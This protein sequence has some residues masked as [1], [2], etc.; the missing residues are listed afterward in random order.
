MTLLRTTALIA[1]A[2]AGCRKAEEAYVD[3]DGD[4]V[5]SDLD[6]DD[7]DADAH[8]GAD[9]RC[10]GVDNDCDAEID[11][12]PVDAPTWYADADSDGYGDPDTS[13]E[14]CEAPV[15]FV[16][17]A[18]DCDDTNPTFHPGAPETDCTDANDYNCDGS[19]GYADADA[20]GVPAC[21]D[22]DD[23]RADVL[24]GADELCDG[25]DNDCDALVD[26]DAVDAETWYADLDHDGHADP[27]NA[28][29]AC[30]APAGWLATADDCDDL[31]SSVYPGADELCDGA[32]ND[33]D[34]GVDHNAI[35]A[36]PWYADADGDRYG[37]PLAEV[38]GCE[39]PQGYVDDHSD[40]DDTAPSTRPGAVELCDGAD[41]DCDGSVDEEALDAPTWY[42]DGDGDSYGLDGSGVRACAQPEGSAARA[43]D[44]DDTSAAR[45]PTNPE[46]CDGVDNN[47]DGGVDL[48]AVDA[49]TWYRDLDLDG[50][51]GDLVTQTSCSQPPGA[52]WHTTGPDCRDLDPSIHPAAADTCDG[53]DNNCDGL[54]DQT[55][56]QAPFSFSQ[57]PDASWQLSGDASWL[58][59]MVR[60]TEAV[61]AS[62]GGLFY[63]PALGADR[64]FT[65]FSFEMSAGTGGDGLALAILDDR[66]G[67]VGQS[68]GCEDLGGL[69]VALST[70]GEEDLVEV[71][72][73]LDW[74]APYA[75]AA[76]APLSGPHTGHVF[77]DQGHL[78][79][80]VDQ[81]RVLNTWI[82]ADDFPWAPEVTLGWTAGTGALNQAHDVDDIVIGCATAED[83]DGDGSAMPEDCDD[84]DPTVSAGV[85]GGC[86]DGL[87]CADALARDP[88]RL[89][90]DGRYLID[91]DGDS[92]PAAPRLEWCD[93]TTDGGGWTLVFDWSPAEG[94]AGWDSFWSDTVFD[95]LDTESFGPNYLRLWDG[96]CTQDVQVKRHP[97]DFPNGGEV[98]MVHHQQLVSFEGGGEWIA[99]ELSSDGSLENVWCHD[100]HPED[101]VSSALFSAEELA[102]M[103]YDA[104]PDFDAYANGQSY[105]Y[106]MTAQSALSGPIDALRWVLFEACSGD[107]HF[108]YSMSFAVR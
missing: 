40:C 89:S 1:L 10:D 17:N 49:T 86:V 3:L 4:G 31:A 57:A 48:S 51:G 99:G 27:D 107:D 33:C 93:M 64:W 30:E 36:T 16:D 8:P 18:E 82:P 75:S 70:A 23:R 100:Q 42:T 5:L 14:A 9:E 38:I 88:S 66:T 72:H 47:C 108:L 29:R 67:L 95:N 56:G 25:A 68:L 101:H 79:V 106:D 34:G 6:C 87:S 22:C 39:A 12:D 2:L 104:C 44:C 81:A 15:D 71:R 43:G 69:C 21:E 32:D 103:P 97:I 78:Q 59:G 73:G 91:P 28:V 63:L 45:F 102:W 58:T 11:E 52:D 37:D 96:N 77:W 35:D 90:L 76:V 55:L 53:V 7:T 80:F 41:N 92:G 83:L 61:D 94:A 13:W 84:S 20:D 98:R 74:G 85:A 60:L 62:A 65:S 50:F 54:V 24:P 105:T 19:V 26:E 46:V